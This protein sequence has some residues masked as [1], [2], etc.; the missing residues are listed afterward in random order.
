MA[1][2]LAFRFDLDGTLIDRGLP[3]R[4]GMAR[5]IRCRRLRFTGVRIHRR[6]GT[7]R[8]HALDYPQPRL[9]GKEIRGD[10]YAVVGEA[11]NSKIIVRKAL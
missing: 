4:A 2:K 6:I 10:W 9:L 3:G 8:R 11:T 1:E 5:S 7:S